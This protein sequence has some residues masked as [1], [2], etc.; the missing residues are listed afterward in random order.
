MT[1]PESTCNRAARQHGA[2]EGSEPPVDLDRVRPLVCRVAEGEVADMEMRLGARDFSLDAEL[3]ELVH[4]L[5]YES[6]ELDE[7][8][9]EHARVVGLF[10][11]R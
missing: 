6:V 2:M 3:D 10:G 9:G 4:E 11:L 8:L 1:G 5:A 7:P